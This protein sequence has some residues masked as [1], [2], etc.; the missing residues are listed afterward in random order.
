[1]T[2]KILLLGTKGLAKMVIEALS[3]QSTNLEIALL[4]N[5]PEHS[6]LF[7][8]PI[9]GKC[10]DL[11]TF[12][13]EYTHAF[14][15][16]ADNDTRKRF[17]QKALE[18]GY[19]IPCI[20]H[21][22]AYVSESALIGNGVFI[23]ALSIVQSDSKLGCG[24]ILNSGSIV[25]HDNELGDYVTMAPNATTTGYVKIEENSFLGAGCSVINSVHIGKNV[26]VAAGATVISDVQSN[27]MVAGCPAKVKRH[28]ENA[29]YKKQKWD[30]FEENDNTNS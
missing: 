13:S 20:V 27:V 21:P 29:K 4:D 19:E 22:R 14:I 30:D 18:A 16:I 10:D 1:M 7:S 5:Y 3:G 15:C 23:N 25:E 11:E 24:C 6:H 28:I 12:A 2:K 9:I 26:L 8:Y 17:M